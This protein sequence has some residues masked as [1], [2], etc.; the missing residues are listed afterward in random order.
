MGDDSE[1]PIGVNGHAG[2]IVGRV[3]HAVGVPIASVL[4]TNTVVTVGTV[5]AL[6]PLAAMRTLN[7][8]RMGSVRGGDGVG[9]PEIH[10]RAAS[11]VPPVSSVGI[12]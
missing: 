5:T 8:A 12:A 11:A 7:R 10:L 6:K 3:A 1:L 4:V 2:A 9:L